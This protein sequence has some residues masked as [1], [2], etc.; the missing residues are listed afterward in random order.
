MPKVGPWRPLSFKRLTPE[1]EQMYM[2]SFNATITRYRELLAEQNAGRLKVPNDNLDVGTFT[3]A[4]KYTLEDSSYAEVLHKLQGHYT[5]I[6][7]ELRS[8]ILAFYSGP[9]L[10]NST[11]TNAGDS[12]RVVKELDQLRAVDVDLART[13]T[14]VSAGV[15][16]APRQ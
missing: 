14:E 6:S 3:A 10:A 16:S 7:P 9:G 12:A 4:G 2:A 1:I 5:E 13:G 15:G 11:K 8:D